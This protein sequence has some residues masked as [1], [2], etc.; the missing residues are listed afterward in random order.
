MKTKWGATLAGACP[1]SSGSGPLSQ[2]LS[3]PLSERPFVD[4]GSDKGCDKGPALL[5][6]LGEAL[7]LMLLAGCAVGP[8]FKKPPAPEARDYTASP[9]SLMSSPTNVLG[10]GVQRFNQALD[11]SAE[12]WTLFHSK[13]L[14]ALIERS[15]TNNPSL[16]AAQAAL[17]VARENVLA[18]KGAYFPSIAGSFAAARAKTSQEISPTPNSGACISTF[19][20]RRS[21]CRMCRTCLA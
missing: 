18:Q 20:R 21:V 5:G 15:L 3:M 8:N 14:N 17:A 1:K 13:P 12:W 2:P 10:G 19:I 4:K 11:I 16:K 6:F 9:L 7:T